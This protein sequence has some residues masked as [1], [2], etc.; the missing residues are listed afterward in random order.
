MTTRPRPERRCGAAACV[1]KKLPFTVAPSAASRSASVTSSK[2]LGAKPADAPLTTTSSPPSSPA[3][4][5]TSA[6][7][8]SRRDTSPSRLP[9]ATT[10]QPWARNSSTTPAPSF[11]V[12]PVTSARVRTSLICPPIGCSARTRVESSPHATHS[13]R[14]HPRRGAHRSAR[15]ARRDEDG[16]DQAIGLRAGDGQ[17]RRG[18]HHPLEE[19]RHAQPPDRLDDR[20][21]RL[22]GAG[23]EPDVF[24]QVRV[25]RH[26]P[27]PGRAQSERH[28]DGARRRSAPVGDAR[29]LRAADRLRR[30]GDALG[31][32]EQQARRRAGADRPAAVRPAVA[33]RARDGRDRDGR[34]LRLHGHAEDPHDLPG[35]LEDVE[36][37]RHHDRSGAD[38]LVR[39][40]ERF[41]HARLRGT[42]DGPQERAAAAPHGVGAV[43]DDQARV[44]S[45]RARGPASR[46]R[47]PSASPACGSRCRS[48]RP[49]SATSRASAARSPTAAA[50]SR[51]EACASAPA[52]SASPPRAS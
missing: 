6:R 10:R 1:T 52:R 24:V 19:R 7:A 13:D 45:T 35:A 42:L 43:G 9:A 48:I 46:R 28:R 5:S 15:R 21:V 16:P 30:E 50:P 39:A 12:P 29:D 40:D 25:R 41:R 2:G 27:V 3:A 37:P 32:G 17:H 51:A 47:C 34:H 20:H 31:P 14:S 33:D 18:R 49:A 38:D 22:A 36:E 8:S 26:L 4:R 11:P 23:A 44:C